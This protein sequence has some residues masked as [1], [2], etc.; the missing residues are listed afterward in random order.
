MSFEVLGL[1]SERERGKNEREEKGKRE[2]ERGKEQEEEGQKEI[3]IPALYLFP[4][5]ISCTK[6]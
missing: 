6:V 4:C 1:R 3:P 2:G 5:F